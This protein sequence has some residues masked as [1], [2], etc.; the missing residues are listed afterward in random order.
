MGQED[1]LD[2]FVRQVCQQGHERCEWGNMSELHGRIVD[3]SH[4]DR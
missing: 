2:E 4:K 1:I 3:I